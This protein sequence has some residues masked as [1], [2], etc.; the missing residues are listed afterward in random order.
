MKRAALILTVLLGGC[1]SSSSPTEPAP[2][3]TTPVSTFHLRDAL[4]G[5]N[6]VG[7]TIVVGGQTI[8]VPGGT[9]GAPGTAQF[10]AGTYSY[11]ANGNPAGFYKTATGTFTVQVSPATNDFTFTLLRTTQ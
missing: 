2:T 11:T 10:S 6:T 8:S 1:G 9:G 7:G 5:F 3:P 4:S